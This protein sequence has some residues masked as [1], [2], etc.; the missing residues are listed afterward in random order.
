MATVLLATDGS[1]FATEALREGVALLGRDHHFLVL[2]AVAPLPVA[3][4]GGAMGP[5]P[6]AVPDASADAEVADAAQHQADEVVRAAIDALGIDVSAE[7]IVAHGDPAAEICRHAEDRAADVVVV[8]SKGHG[9]LARLV[10]GSVSTY[11]V[12]HAPCPVLVV[13][14]HEPDGEG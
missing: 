5:A 11:V 2:C 10:L 12:N 4:G 14:H 13:R 7:G 3:L 8:G 9:W 6:V 1:D